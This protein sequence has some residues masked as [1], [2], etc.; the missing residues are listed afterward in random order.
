MRRVLLF[1][2]V[3]R[4]LLRQR[5]RALIALS[6]VATGVAALI[7]AE[8][9][10]EWMFVDF[11]EAMIASQYA[12]L[13]VTRPRF[14][15]E[16]RADPRRFLLPADVTAASLDRMPHVK[17]WGPRLVL[18]GLV[19]HGDATL[20]F[21]G[22]GY[23]PGHD[24]VDDRALRIVAGRRLAG[25]DDNHVMLGEG[26][27]RQLG[28]QPGT[29]LVLLVEDAKTGLAAIEVNV[30]GIFASV[31]RA[32]DDAAILM[33]IS[34][35]RRLLKTDG[36]HAWYV[37][38]DDTSKAAAVAEVLAVDYPPPAYE[39]RRWDELAEFYR[40]AV[41]LLRQQLAVVRVIVLAIILLGIGNTMM[42]SVMERTGE[43]GTMMALGVRRRAVL[44]QFLAEGALIGLL[45]GISGLLLAWLASIGVDALRIEMPPPPGLTRGYVARILLTPTIAAE[46]MGI[47]VVTTVLASLYPAW[48]ASRMMIVDALRK[49]K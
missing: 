8:G 46:A 30:A 5:R 45:G 16:G 14:H 22:E 4:N 2:I 40:R 27:A 10:L 19:S 33:P 47:A 35:A 25:G 44:N 17:S 13:Q 12:H 34:A 37:Y 11:R 1:F 20:A 31:S 29:T 36:A 23:A 9:Y 48:K 18:S 15:E 24:L 38:L 7:V 21:L 28:V 26:L 39:I 42:M 32:Y 43:I 41:E 49:N 6:S 3:L